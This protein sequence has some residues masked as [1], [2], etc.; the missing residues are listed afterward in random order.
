MKKGLLI[1]VFGVLVALGGAYL[2]ASATSEKAYV[3]ASFSAARIKSA[4]LAERIVTLSGESL[5][6]LD[7]I[8]SYDRSGQ[9]SEALI[10]ISV[11]VLKN[12]SIHEEAIKLSAELEHMARAVSEIK[13][14]RARDLASEGVASEVALVSRL[15]GYN[16]YLRRVFELLQEK[17]QRP[18]LET[19]GRVQELISKINEEGKAINELNARATGALAEFDKVFA[20]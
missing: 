4:L 20:F 13:P 16:D 18:G 3:P 1:A 12:K 5:A 19:D 14:S 17:V 2:I 8:S 6:A 15:L 7:Q 11:A 9:K 10:L